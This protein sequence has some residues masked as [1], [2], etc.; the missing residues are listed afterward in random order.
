MPV[1]GSGNDL[2]KGFTG[3]EW[4]Q[5]LRDGQA[6][7]VDRVPRVPVPKPLRPFA[8]AAWFAR[9]WLRASFR[10]GQRRAEIVGCESSCPDLGAPA[11]RGARLSRTVDDGRD[12]SA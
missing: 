12:S 6:L 5:A 3:T 10:R 9:L 7:A 2:P 4:E 11:V 8:A 1:K